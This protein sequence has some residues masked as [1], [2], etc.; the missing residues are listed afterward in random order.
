M[1]R[2]SLDRERC[3]TNRAAAAKRRSASSPGFLSS[4][5]PAWQGATETPV[6]LVSGVCEHLLNR[7]FQ[8]GQIARD[9][10]PDKVEVY[11]EVFMDHIVTHCGDLSPL[12][13]GFGFFQAR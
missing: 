12:D 3:E 13:A 2:Q 1:K 11:A 8:R 9:H 10:G 6:A 5:N 4:P 7:S